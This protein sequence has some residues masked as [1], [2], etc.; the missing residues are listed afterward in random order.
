MVTWE[1]TCMNTFPASVI[2]EETKLISPLGNLLYMIK[3][4]SIET[5]GAE[6]ASQISNCHYLFKD[7]FYQNF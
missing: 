7:I 6:D 5:F 3:Q 1:A 2:S 4:H